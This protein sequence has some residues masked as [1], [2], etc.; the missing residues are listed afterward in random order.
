M[1]FSE[2]R[3]GRVFILRL[4]DGEVVHETIERFA[5]EQG[6]EAAS[7]TLVGG[8][9]A[10]SQLVVGPRHDR[11]L[12]LEPLQ[13]QLDH[14]HEVAGVGTLFCDE[15]GVPLVHLHMAC[16]RG[17]TTVTGCI[18][19]GVRVWRVLEVIVQELVGSTARRR[20]EQPLN[21]HLLQP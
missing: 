21:V 7:L 20:L 10:G 8:A 16:G 19:G 1:R 15:A 18:R 2:A 5:R 13:H 17:A 14:V 12:P 3:L 9:D 6:I 4:E 11:I